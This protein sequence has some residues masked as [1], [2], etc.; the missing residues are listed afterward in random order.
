MIS[1]RG[2]HRR[3]I[4]YFNRLGNFFRFF[5][6]NFIASNPYPE[7]ISEI[8]EKKVFQKLEK[9]VDTGKSSC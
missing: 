8:W 3:L 2:F 7:S 9:G 6:K 4:K 5:Q 1:P